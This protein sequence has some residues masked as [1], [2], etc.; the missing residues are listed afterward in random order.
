[1]GIITLET[2]ESLEDSGST[3][4]LRILIACR[5]VIVLGDCEPCNSSIVDDECM[6]LATSNDSV[7][8]GS[9]VVHLHVELLGELGGRIAHEA[10]VGSINLLILAPSLHDGSVVDAV[11]EYLVNPGSL[12]SVLIL[13]K[14][15]DLS[16]GSGRRE[17]PGEAADDDFA[18]FAEIGQ[19]DH[20][21]R[22]ETLVQIDCGNAISNFDHGSECGSKH[23]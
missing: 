15:G 3:G 14:A 17:G 13:N 5:V 23:Q 12:E 1:M 7:G 11:H 18:P 20:L 10:D 9:G 4:V 21:G 6:T 16:C 2:L 8:G 19:A 22:A